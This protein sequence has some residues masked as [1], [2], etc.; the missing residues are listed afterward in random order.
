MSAEFLCKKNSIDSFSPHLVSIYQSF[1]LIQKTY[2]F[3]PAE[4]DESEIQP[5]EM[6]NSLCESVVTL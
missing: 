2:P 4:D 6:V 3:E 1:S 5:H